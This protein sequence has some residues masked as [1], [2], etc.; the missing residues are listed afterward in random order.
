MQELWGP[1]KEE[2]VHMEGPREH[3]WEDL[4]DSVPPR[5][6]QRATV[7]TAKGT[8]SCCEAG[9]AGTQ[10]SPLPPPYTLASCADF[11]IV[12]FLI[13]RMAVVIP[14]CSDSLQN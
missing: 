8:V 10:G 13:H 7:V 9:V 12:R 11:P 1:A 4:R 2:W 6:T 14:L 3:V 5:G